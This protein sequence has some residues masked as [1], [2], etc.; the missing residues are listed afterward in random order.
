M[1]A[2]QCAKGKVIQ[3][4]VLLGWGVLRCFNGKLCLT[5][6]SLNEYRVGT[7]KSVDI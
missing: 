3:E 2:L 4:Y 1:E 5:V 6:P 7:S